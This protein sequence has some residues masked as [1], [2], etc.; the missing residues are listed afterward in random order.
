MTNETATAE[1]LLD[2]TLRNLRSAWTEFSDSTRYYLSGAPRPDLPGDD[3]AKIRQQMLDCLEAKGGEVSARA[4]AAELGRSYL[5]LN[6]TGRHRFL[7]LLAEQFGPD[8]EEVSAAVAVLQDA[9]SEEDRRR[10]ERRLRE[11]L[12]PHWRRLLTRFTALPEGVKFLVDL[13]A[14]LLPMARKSPEL[15]DLDADLREL[16]AAWFDV[17]LLELRRITWEAPA[18][19][20]EKLIAYEAVHKIRSWEDLKNRLDSDRRCFAYFHPNMPQ[21]PLIFVEVALVDGM[22]DGVQ[23]LL[24]ESAPSTDPK[25]ANTAIFYSISNAQRGLAGISFGNFLIKRVVDVLEHEFPNLKTFATLSPIPGFGSWY[26]EAIKVGE[27][28]KLTASERRGVLQALGLE[29]DGTSDTDLVERA[30]AVEQWWTDPALADAVKA[31]MMRLAARYLMTAK[32][33]NGTARDPVAHFHLSNGARMER[34]NWLGDPSP[35]GLRQSRGMMIN[36]LYKLSEIDD[37]HEAYSDGG[38]VTASSAMRALAR[39]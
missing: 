6:A 23:A 12:V 18:A 20:L 30:L 15:A 27:G 36:Y 8:R 17:G 7:A 21:E 25:A 14:E 19:L 24:D 26:A 13:R 1:S 5:A 29:D 16:L 3:L 4:R 9:E 22:S 32:R 31:P 10:A 11:A 33:G 34:L 35:N 2:R 38:R 39:S 28:P 37:N